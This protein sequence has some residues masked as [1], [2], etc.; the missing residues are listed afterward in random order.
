ME[1]TMTG[2]WFM[3]VDG[4]KPFDGDPRSDK[5]KWG[6]V[7]GANDPRIDAEFIAAHLSEVILTLAFEKT[8]LKEMV[9]E[10]DWA[11]P[12]FETAILLGAVKGDKTALNRLEVWSTPRK[13]G[14]GWIK[15]EKIDAYRQAVK[16][17]NE[18]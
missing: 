14:L 17:I 7:N 8:D 3:K 13:D 12:I 11:F 16:Q 10:K 5:V 1:E 4:L 6:H 9:G 15:Q 18:S 2:G